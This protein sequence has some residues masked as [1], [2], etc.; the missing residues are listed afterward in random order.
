MKKRQREFY[1]SLGYEPD[2]L[3]TIGRKKGL[4]RNQVT[5]GMEVLFDKMEDGL[6]VKRIMIARLALK[7]AE[8]IKSAE[9]KTTEEYI[10][11]L[12]EKLDNH[13]EYFKLAI[14][15][16]AALIYIIVGLLWRG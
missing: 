1:N 8:S 12:E 11:S 15:T 6:E 10:E 4:N 14:V 13:K 7:E 2:K 5:K 16:H 9:Y 3:I